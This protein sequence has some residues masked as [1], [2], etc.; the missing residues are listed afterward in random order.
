MKKGDLKTFPLDVMQNSVV[1]NFDHKQSMVRKNV[2]IIEIQQY[3][4]WPKLVKIVFLWV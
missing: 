2:R 3:S 4:E 1:S